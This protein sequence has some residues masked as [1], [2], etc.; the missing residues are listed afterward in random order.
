[1]QGLN[2]LRSICKDLKLAG[3]DELADKVLCAL[4]A[5]TDAEHP[6]V[7][8]S[9]TYVMRKLR[10]EGD[11]EKVRKFQVVFKNTFDRALDED[12]E[13]PAELALMQAI[14]HIDFQG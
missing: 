5:V 8:L 2:E 3:E 10:K 1:M 13:D 12:L 11:P 14:K 6:R 7:D 9:Y 4:A